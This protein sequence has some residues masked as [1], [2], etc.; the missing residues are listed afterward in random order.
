M[1][2]AIARDLVNIAGY[3]LLFALLPAASAWLG[4]ARA[5]GIAAGIAAACYPM[6]GLS[7]LNTAR[8]EWLAAIALLL[9][10]VYA[11]RLARQH[12]LT[13]RS[14]LLYGAGWG[15]LMYSQ[16]TLVSILPSTS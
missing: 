13:R 14:V 3:S 12:E 15:A 16:P 9:L 11:W 1:N 7:E 2:G 10:T 5:P 4:M 6:F 8:D